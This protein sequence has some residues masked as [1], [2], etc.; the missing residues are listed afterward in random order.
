MS[1]AETWDKRA[2]YI[3]VINNS[4]NSIRAECTWYGIE[5]APEQVITR[6]WAWA[7]FNENPGVGVWFGEKDETTKLV[8]QGQTIEWDGQKAKVYE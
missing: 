4:K 7:V 5:M 3:R 8:H 2:K 6:D 1:L